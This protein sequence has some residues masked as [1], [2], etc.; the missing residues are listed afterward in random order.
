MRN[1][2]PLAG[3]TIAANALPARLVFVKFGKRK[4]F[5][6]LGATLGWFHWGLNV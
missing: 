2:F 1:S 3:L 5:A 6:A 4:C